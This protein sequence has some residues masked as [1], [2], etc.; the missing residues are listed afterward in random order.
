MK[1]FKGE[2][3][4]KSRAR[5]I[6][7][8]DNLDGNSGPDGPNFYPSF[9]RLVGRRLTNIDAK[10]LKLGIPVATYLGSHA[11]H[12]YVHVRPIFRFFFIF[13]FFYLGFVTFEFLHF[14]V[15]FSVGFFHCWVF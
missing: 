13:N 6:Q 1:K 14:W 10:I 4:R 11:P 12:S 3:P 2:K 5:V 7:R 15:F 9:R 8:Q